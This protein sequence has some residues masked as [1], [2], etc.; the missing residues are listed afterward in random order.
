[1]SGPYNGIIGV[2]RDII[3]KK[4]LTHMPVKHEVAKGIVQFNAVIMEIDEKNG[5]TIKIERLS[6]LLNFE[7][8]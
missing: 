3:I 1:M 5:K 6:R 8:V 7:K 2:N 4:F